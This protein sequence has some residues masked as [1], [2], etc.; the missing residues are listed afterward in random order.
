MNQPTSNAKNQTHEPPVIETH[1]AYTIYGVDEKGNEVEQKMAA[2]GER[3]QDWGHPRWHYE[4]F[5]FEWLTPEA[6][7]IND[8]HCWTDL[9]REPG[10]YPGLFASLVAMI[11]QPGQ[12]VEL[13]GRE[14]LAEDDFWSKC[15]GPLPPIFAQEHDED[16]GIWIP[17][18]ALDEDDEPKNIDGDTDL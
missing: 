14:Y 2:I 10:Q 5:R 9:R 1:N 8:A 3:P 15:W 4:H 16:E 13:C 7:Y 6:R 12:P 18:S 11:L 17:D